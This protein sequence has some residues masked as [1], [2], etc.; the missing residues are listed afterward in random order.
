MR[1]TIYFLGVRV[2]NLTL[3]QALRRINGYISSSK[4]IS[5]SRK[6]FFTNVHSIHLA[7]K[8][9]DL[10]RCISNADMVLPDGS[11]LKIAG[12]VLN[13]P[14]KENLNG[15]DFTPIVCLM[16]ESMGRSVYLLGAKKDVLIKCKK[17]LT[18]EFPNLNIIGAQH[19][20]FDAA[21]EKK[22]IEDINKKKPD[23][24][25][26][27]MG[28]PFQEKWITHN[29]PRLKAR[30]CL[31]VGGLFDFLSE[32][33]ERAPLWMRKLGLEWVFRLLQDPRSK[34][35]R[36]FIE[37]PVFFY[38]IMSIRAFQTNFYRT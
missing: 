36:V 13:K 8:D 33:L 12:K 29:A 15:T 3:E 9:S 20:Y 23:I 21:E 6:V 5:C 26:V 17:N 27:A 22:I 37:I 7:K 35:S 31:A 14:V 24:L 30:I 16:A 4:A 32:E 34:W 2:D 38:L 28:S 18:K 25:L 10:Y 1:E 19:G 11:G